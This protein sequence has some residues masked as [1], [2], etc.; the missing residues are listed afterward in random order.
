MHS[1]IL[2]GEESSSADEKD[3]ATVTSSEVLSFACVAVKCLNN[4][5][6]LDL[7]RLQVLHYTE[8]HVWQAAPAD[9]KTKIV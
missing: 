3:S 9:S 7:R 6:S 8:V 4:L 5:A 1:S 2:L